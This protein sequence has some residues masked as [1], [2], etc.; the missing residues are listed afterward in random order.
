M[1][2]HI[3]ACSSMLADLDEMLFD[4]NTKKYIEAICKDAYDSLFGD[5][6]F[7]DGKCAILL[8]QYISK[9]ILRANRQ[10]AKVIKNALNDFNR[11]IKEERYFSGP[12]I[13]INNVQMNEILK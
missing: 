2:R 5:N 1:Y 3:Q 12:R 9:K 10:F 7:T 8:R 13:E 6:N 11:N 4:T